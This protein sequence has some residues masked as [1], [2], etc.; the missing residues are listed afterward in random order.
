MRD[1]REQLRECCP[2]RVC[3]MGLGNPERGDDGFGVALAREMM[4]SGVGGGSSPDSLP[5][6]AGVPGSI[7]RMRLTVMVAG[8]APERYLGRV[9]EWGGEHLVFLDAVDFG[10]A[11]GSAVWLS[12]GE[13]AAR[14][15]QVSTHKLSLGLLARWVEAR[16]TTKV[17]LLGVQPESVRP[18]GDLSPA[19]RASLEALGGLLKEVWGRDVGADVPNHL[20]T[21][22]RVGQASCLPA[23]RMP[24]SPT[25][26]SA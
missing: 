23:G 13:M 12:G 4:R 18:G 24:A 8:T 20:S 22:H 25:G 7:P 1:L 14:F 15:P 6:E 26:V 2:G 21:G 17:W 19:V 16:G 11:P 10:G 9:A 5:A 3:L